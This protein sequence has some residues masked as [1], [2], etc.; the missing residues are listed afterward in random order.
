MNVIHVILTVLPLAVAVVVLIWWQHTRAS[1]ILRQWAQK[2][3]FEVISANK[4][5]I[6]T[7]PF[8]MDH[9]RGQFVFRIVVR[10]R[11][12]TKRTGWLLVGGW[13]AGVASNKSRISWDS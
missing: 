6:R 9:S 5:Y 3:G 11:S 8:F 4:R 13:L 2:D 1:D 12:G 10:D 7:G